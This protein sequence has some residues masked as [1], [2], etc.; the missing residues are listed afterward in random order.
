[1]LNPSP[2][3]LAGQ[4]GVRLGGLDEDSSLKYGGHM[5]KSP[6]LEKTFYPLQHPTC[7]YGT[8][9]GPQILPRTLS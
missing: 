5:A 2:T 3:L 8:Y 9:F 6:T 4:L 1:M 7:T